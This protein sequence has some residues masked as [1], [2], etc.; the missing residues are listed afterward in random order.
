MQ[1][2][3]RSGSGTYWGTITLLADADEASVN[4][5]AVTEISLTAPITKV[6]GDASISDG[7]VVGTNS[8]APTA[9][10]V[11][12]TGSLVSRKA[13]VDHT[14]YIY[15]PY[16]TK[17]TNA[18]WD[19][20]AKTAADNGTLDLS[21]LFSIPANA[22]AVCAR[23]SIQSASVNIAV[24]LGPSSSQSYYLIARTQVANQYTDAFGIVNCD[25]NGDFY[26]TI[27]G[28]VNVF[29][30]IFGYFI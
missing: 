10:N 12:Y 27:N 13:S 7:L 11:L 9:G 1:L 22:K 24:G 14:G 4:L 15:I 20:D 3:S 29:I 18:S 16:T 2:R 30:E 23:L 26:I 21:S 8:V 25:A 28:S 19:G 6:W 5:G 17:K